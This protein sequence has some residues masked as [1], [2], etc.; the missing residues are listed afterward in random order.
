MRL[1]SEG[2][3]TNGMVVDG[4]EERDEVKEGLIINFVFLFVFLFVFV[5]VVCNINQQKSWL[6]SSREA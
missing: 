5:V 3:Y 2:L 6:M 4:G 1:G